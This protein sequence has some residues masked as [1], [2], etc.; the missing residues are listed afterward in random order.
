MNKEQREKLALI[1]VLGAALLVGGHAFK[2]LT[3][4]PSM[5]AYVTMKLRSAGVS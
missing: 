4:K 2:P 1:A 5:T 3:N